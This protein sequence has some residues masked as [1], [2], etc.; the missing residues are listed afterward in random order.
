MFSLVPLLLVQ[1]KNNQFLEIQEK[2]DQLV[3]KKSIMDRLFGKRNSRSNDKKDKFTTGY[4]PDFRTRTFL[5][6]KT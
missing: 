2:Y 6:D 1:N 3:K 4:S 5:D